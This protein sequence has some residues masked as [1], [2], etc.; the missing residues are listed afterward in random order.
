MI[1]QYSDKQMSCNLDSKI[2][3]VFGT[4]EN[5]TKGTNNAL[6]KIEL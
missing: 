3:A 4:D 6:N 5:G 2:A 1:C